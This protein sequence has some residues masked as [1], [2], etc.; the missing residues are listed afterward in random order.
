MKA[1]LC[2]YWPAYQNHKNVLVT[3]LQ[4][5]EAVPRIEVVT[6]RLLHEERKLKE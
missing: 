5:N 2:T 4:G 6:E 3:A 1:V